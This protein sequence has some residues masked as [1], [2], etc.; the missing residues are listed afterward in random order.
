MS[1]PKPAATVLLLRDGSEGP[2]VFMVQRNR[3]VGFL[4]NAWVFPGGRVDATDRLGQH[5]SVRGDL[6]VPGESD[7][8]VA[9]AIGVAA[10][11][12]TFEES[13]L[14]L[15]PTAPGA[16]ARERLLA[17]GAFTE[18]LEQALLDLDLLRAW[19]W[20]VTPE[21]EPRRYDTRFL[22][23]RAPEGEARHD[24]GETVASSWISPRRALSATD[25]AAFPMAPPTWW[26]LRELAEHDDVDAVLAA[27]RPAGTPI[28]PILE[29]G[30]QGLSLKLPG[31][32]EHG[33]PAVP[34]LADGITWDGQGWAA[35]REGTRI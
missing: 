24:E 31:H 19:S 27:D 15:G 21:V 26:T 7:R 17:G 32:P 34:G 11:R 29:F 14:W 16:G 22:V 20:W 13:G 1:E 12:E 5:A 23:A 3:R 9:R 18:L 6:V 2:E 8:E 33:A 30:D 25:Q 4:P 10:I 35:W 28:Q